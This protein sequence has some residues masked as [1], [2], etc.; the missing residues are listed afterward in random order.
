YVPV[1][2]DL[3]AERVAHIVGCADPVLVLEELPDVTGYPSH[4]P[5][6][7]IGPDHAAYVIFTSGSTGGPKGVVVSH[8]SIMNRIGW[9]LEHFQVTAEDRTMLVT[10]VGFDVS[11]PEL[12]GPLQRGGAIVI[13]RPDGRRDPAYLARLIQEQRVTDVDFVP[14]LLEAFVGEPAAAGCTS[15][16][17]IEV[18]GEAFAPELAGRFAQVLPGVAVFNLYGPTEAAVE[19]TGH[20]YRPGEVTVPIGRPITNTRVYVLDGALRPV[21]PGVVGELYLAG[22]GLARGYLGRP[23]LTAGRF[24]ACPYAVGER[25]YRTGDLVRWNTDGEL[26]YVGRADFQVKVRGFRIEPGEIEQVLA[27]HPGVEK[28]LAVVRE[29]NPGDQRLVAYVIPKADASDDLGSLLAALTNT[30][31]ERLPEYMVPSAFVPLAELPL[32]ASGK[33]DRRALPAPEH[34]GAAGGRRPRNHREE[35][36]ARLFAEILGLDQVGIDDDFFALGGHSLLATRLIGRIRTELGIDIPI[37]TVFRTPTVA[38]LAE[39]SQE[40]AATSR[41]RLRKMTVEE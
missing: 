33:V 17:R 26:E 41:P 35:V 22:T 36:L 34:T 15:L 13:A 30:A 6:V 27:A 8:R 39:R 32:N 4:N 11:V 2:P 16:R 3:P 19:V 18:A 31:R 37:R 24:V 14:S 9:G 1:E 28:A 5:G 40:L 25:M 10:S 7:G 12:F 20:R 29:D 23:G 21:P 38:Q